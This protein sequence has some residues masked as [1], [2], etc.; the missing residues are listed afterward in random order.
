MISMFIEYGGQLVQFPVNPPQLSVVTDTNDELLDVIKLGEVSEF[1]YISLSTIEIECF[2]PATKEAP[3]ILTKGKF[4]KPQQYIDFLEKIM[5]DRK[6]FRFTVSGSKINFLASIESFTYGPI[7]GTDDINYTLNIRQY[8]EH[9]AKFVK[10]VK[11]TVSTAKPQTSTKKPQTGSTNKKVTVGCEVIVNGRLHRDSYGTGP[12]QTE[13]NA[14][15]YVNFIAPGRKCPI[16]VRLLGKS[17]AQNTWR[18]WVTEG[19][20][21]RV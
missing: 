19:S 6:P 16:H 21:K 17:S 2:F 4:W 9:S 3:Y 10:V 18:G 7:A 11:Q 15:R 20:V 13:K 12:G 8:K 1:G 14:R 5:K